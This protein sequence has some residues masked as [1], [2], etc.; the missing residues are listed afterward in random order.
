MHV[1]TNSACCKLQLELQWVQTT[2]ICL[3]GHNRDRVTLTST[4]SLPL[5]RHKHSCPNIQNALRHFAL[6]FNQDRAARHAVCWS[7]MS[8]HL[9]TLQ[10]KSCLALRIITAITI[11]THQQSPVESNAT[12]KDAAEDIWPAHNGPTWECTQYSRVE[13]SSTSFAESKNLD[14]A[15]FISVSGT[16]MIERGVCYCALRNEFRKDNYFG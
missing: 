7:W 13:S 12:H 5:G 11:H 1:T 15:C 2:A 6:V 10:R 16:Q 9:R 14:T 8:S 4:V 3:S